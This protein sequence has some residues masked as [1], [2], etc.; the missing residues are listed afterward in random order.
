[1]HPVVEKIIFA[2]CISTIF[3]PIIDF[4]RY[5]AEVRKMYKN[6]RKEMDEEFRKFEADPE[7]YTYTPKE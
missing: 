3:L 6:L 5:D 4:I 7:N 1:M 2:V